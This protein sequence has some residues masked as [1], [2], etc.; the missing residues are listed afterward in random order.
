MRAKGN[1]TNHDILTNLFDE[2]IITLSRKCNTQYGTNT[3]I[4]K[5]PGKKHTY[6]HT[7]TMHARTHTR[8]YARTHVRAYTHTHTHTLTHIQIGDVEVLS[9][10]KQR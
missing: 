9:I 10:H 3:Q 5:H 6:T 4:R 2:K 8:S 7:H 1:I